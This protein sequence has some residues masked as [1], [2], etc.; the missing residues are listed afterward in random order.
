M[1]IIAEMS[2]FWNRIQVSLFPYLETALEEPLTEK[3]K[4]LVRILEVVRIEYYAASPFAQWMGRRQ[5]D[6]RAIARA[7]L[8]K[9]VYDCPTTEMLLDMLRLQPSLRRICGFETRRSIP[10]AST[11]SRAFAQFADAGLGDCVFEALVAENVG[12]KVVMHVSR[13]STEV[14]AR[15]K[16]V[17]KEKAAPKPKRKRGRPKKGE[18]PPPKEPTRLVKQLDQTPE[19]AIAEL[20]R[21]CDVGS[22]VDSKVNKHSWIGWKAHI[23][24][25]DGGIPLNVVTTSASLHDSQVA[26]PMARVTAR[27]VTSLYD[28]MDTGYDADAIFEVS[29]ELGHVA[30]IAPHPNRK[31]HPV[32][33][34]PDRV[35]RYDERTTA[36]RGNSRLKDEF[37]LRHLRVRGHPKAHLHIMF[38]ILALFADRLGHLFSG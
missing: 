12:D 15:E 6:R 5:S 4:Q 8:A 23:D 38:G 2:G 32:P 1:S 37:G 34:E 31:V 36:E 21:L 11:F 13:D 16:P 30:L 19:E 17:R 3:L 10:S 25:A 14:V 29:K 9:A 22:K 35:R 28:L 33:W 26:I 18:E 27:R 24:W 20:P 7:F